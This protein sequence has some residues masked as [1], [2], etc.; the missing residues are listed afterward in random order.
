VDDALRL[1]TKFLMM[2][3]SSMAPFLS[4]SMYEKRAERS[5]SLSFL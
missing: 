1:S 3:L 5:C 2:D 4:R